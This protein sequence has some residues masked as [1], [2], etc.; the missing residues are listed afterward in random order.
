[1]KISHMRTTAFAWKLG[2][3]CLLLLAAFFAAIR[4]GA[5]NAAIEEIRLALFTD[6]SGERITMIREIRLPRAVAAIFTGAA[7]SVAGALMQGMTRNPLADP[8]LLGLT[9]GANAALAAAYALFPGLHAFGKMLACFAGAACGM[10]LVFGIAAMKRDGIAPFRL[11]LAGSAVSIFLYACSDGI[12]LVFK[13]SK[14]VSMWT[15]GGLNGTS[16]AQLEGIAPF[17]A[18][19]ILMAILLSRHVTILSL[20]EEVAVGLGQRIKTI[21]E[22]LFFVIILLAGAAVALVGNLAFVG[23]I[24]P[25]LVRFFVGLDYRFIVPM[26]AVTGAAFML[27]ADLSART[28]SAP[29]ET[30]VMAIAALI[31]LPFFAWI[32][33]K[34]GHSSL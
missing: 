11:V 6:A 12:S 31:G 26:S 15:A 33:R 21:K 8:G 23:L 28:I 14:D 29:Y 30:P 20:N 25:H 3:G 13:I 24:I 5:A 10:F 32:V 1:M 9:A 27:L 17:I 18:A 22:F 7:L 2:I 4:F 16:W 19:G 34:G